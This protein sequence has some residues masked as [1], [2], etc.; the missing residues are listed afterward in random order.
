MSDQEHQ[1]RLLCYVTHYYG[2]SSEFYGKSSYQESEIRKKHLLDCIASLKRIPNATV[3]VCGIK[4]RSLVPIDID[5]SHIERP[6]YL[7]FESLAELSSHVDEYDYFLTV[8]D[9]ILVSE[10]VFSNILEFDRTS[11]VNE[12]LL[13]NRLELLNGKKV[14]TDLVT[15]PGWTINE[16]TF[17]GYTLKVALNPHSG[18]LILSQ[19]KLRYCL[20]RIDTSWRGQLVGGYMASAFAH[21]HRPFAL[22]RPYRNADFH[23]VVHLDHFDATTTSTD[24]RNAA[25]I[26]PKKQ[27]RQSQFKQISKLFMPEIALLAYR[28][29][30]K[31]TREVT[32]A[33]QR[34]T[35]YTLFPLNT[36]RGDLVR[37]TYRAAKLKRYD[38]VIKSPAPRGKERVV[39]G[40]HYFAIALA[41]AF[42]RQGLS[43]KIQPREEWNDPYTEAAVALVLRGLTLY[44]PRGDEFSIMWN[45]SHP[46]KVSLEEYEQYDHVYIASKQWAEYLA[47]QV[48]VPVEPLLQ[49]TDPDVFK[50]AFEPSLERELLFVG[51]TRLIFRKSVQYALGTGY[52]LSI[53]GGGWNKFVDETYIKAKSL[54]N[55]ELHRYYSS[56][57]ILLNDHWSDM[58]AKG[59]VSNRL[60]D[61][62]ACNTLVLTDTGQGVEEAVGDYIETFASEEEFKQKVS[63]LMTH[64]EARKE[65]TKGAR[66]FILKE[67]SF[68]ARVRTMMP[69]I[70]KAI[71]KKRA[72]A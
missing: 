18:I 57:A 39:W 59:F 6:E 48:N 37:S 22:F 50:P 1:P 55:R 36:W 20:E 17:N 28:D 56:C 8:E 41:K 43:C 9:D 21:F 32:G 63:Y 51:N 47:G 62:L 12:V 61:A 19:K 27:S 68:D 46:D 60:Y 40:D 24:P 4:G 30:Q 15:K 14:L 71:L 2:R 35:K 11:L 16:K 25:R 10:D 44:R 49:C 45:I 3:K 33:A 42:E 23:T 54:P 58:L 66:E 52:G 64:P 7:V 65:K 31:I 38:V 69:V 34:I 29:P 13:P 70:R 53:Y 72:I 26:P 5:F 67:H